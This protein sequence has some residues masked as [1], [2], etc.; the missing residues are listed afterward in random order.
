MKKRSAKS[1]RIWKREA[2]EQELM[3]MKI[4]LNSKDDDGSNENA[5]NLIVIH[6]TGSKSSPVPK[7]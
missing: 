5:P 1:F 4:T 6:I 3:M 2:Q 7:V